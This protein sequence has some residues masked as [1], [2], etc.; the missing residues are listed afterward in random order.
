MR[1]EV[2]LDGQLVAYDIV[3]ET[4]FEANVTKAIRP[5][6]KQ[7]LAVRV[8]NPGG[9][10]HW[11]DFDVMNWGKYLIP[12]G[13]GFGGILGDV[14][15]KALNPVYISDIYMQNTPQKTKVNAI[16][17]IRNLTDRKLKQNINLDIV[18]KNNPSIK[19]FSKQIKITKFL[20][21]IAR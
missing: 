21:A 6:E 7:L 14:N 15:L 20:K 19:I 18:E 16:I 1:A 9:N 4:P 5:G 17:S 13:R 8:T 2:Y 10:F 11:Q 12:P 3:G